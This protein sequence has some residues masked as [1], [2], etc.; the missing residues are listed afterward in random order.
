MKDFLINSGLI[1]AASLGN[2]HNADT[3]KYK[4]VHKDGTIFEGDR[5]HFKK[6]FNFNKNADCLFRWS[7]TTYTYKGWKVSCLID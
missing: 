3:T 1:I 6:Q 4:F 2:K 7:G 5:D